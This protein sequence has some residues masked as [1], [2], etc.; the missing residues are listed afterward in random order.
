MRKTVLI[1]GASG[2]IG[3]ALVSRFRAGGHFVIGQYCRNE[4]KISEM[5]KE[6]RDGAE[7]VRC[8]FS[9]PE[10]AEE[11]ARAICSAYAVDCLVNNAGTDM[12]G[13]LSDASVA[14]ITRTANINLIAPI[15][16]CREAAKA[17]RERG[18]GAIL[19][20]SSI[21]G[22][23]GGSCEAAY[24]ATKGGLNA[25]TKAL[26]RELGPSG[27]RANALS[28]GYV[29]TPMNARFAPGE[30]AE[31]ASRLALGRIG[32]PDEI[33]NAAYFLC[34]DEASYVTGQILGAD[35]GF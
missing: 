29:D 19:N 33:A 7:F 10:S 6:H 16:L 5:R 25:F 15:V 1:T 4:K 34:S 2:G 27:I 26:A 35:G 23:Y 13:L 22:V 28:C 24:S 14:E 3:E 30:A 11:F 9:S 21:W 12:F 31:F 8:D 17:M 18:G 20:V 32:T